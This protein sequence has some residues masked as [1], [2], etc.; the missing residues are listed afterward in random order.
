MKNSRLIQL[1]E[2]FNKKE[3]R[4]L[5]KYIQCELF[6][7]NKKQH[8]KVIELFQILIASKFKSPKIEKETIYKKLFKTKKID[9]KK[10]NHHITWAIDLVEKYLVHKYLSNNQIEYE[11]LL[12]ESLKKR[13]LENPF[14][15]LKNKIEKK[16]DTEKEKGSTYFYSQYKVADLSLWL[17]NIRDKDTTYI[18]GEFE[19]AITSLDFFYLVNQFDFACH[20]LNISRI[21]NAERFDSPLFL[22]VTDIL[23][24]TDYG[25]STLIQIYWNAYQMLTTNQESYYKTLKSLLFKNY[26]ILPE[27]HHFNLFQYIQN[28]CIAKINEGNSH[29]YSDIWEICI[30]RLEKALI[31]ELTIAA[32]KNLITTGVMLALKKETLNIADVLQF[33]KEYTGKLP[34]N[35][36]KE[37]KT[38]GQSYI[39][40]YQDNFQAVAKKLIISPDPLTLY[41]FEDIYYRIDARRLLI[42]TYFCLEEDDNFDKMCNNLNTFLDERKD[43][44]PELE[45][46][47]NRQFLIFIKKLFWLPINKKEKEKQNQL[48]QIKQEIEAC[49]QVSD[50]KWLLKQIKLILSQI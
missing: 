49:Q 42:M 3:L 10:L 28:Y 47:K 11:L 12:L 50:K 40:F 2:K 23:L 45:I 31:K 43:F 33:I 32:Y 24:Q 35:V 1:L 27:Y 41:K 7:L 22:K 29:Y 38:Y 8:Q 37:A 9:I 19:S 5:Q 46:T 4:E 25:E 44:I 34:E 18:N 13:N 39:S 17:N 21:V 15:Q 36:Q 14:L 26:S 6:H 48:Q 20:T 16:L 30:F